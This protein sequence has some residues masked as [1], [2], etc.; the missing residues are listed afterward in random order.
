MVTT[1]PLWSNVNLT[2]LAKPAFSSAL[3]IASSALLRASFSA[4]AALADKPVNVW[5][6][7]FAE[8]RRLVS[9]PGW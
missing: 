1:R 2:S 4:A 6:D 9:C 5:S 8:G 7:N 3:S